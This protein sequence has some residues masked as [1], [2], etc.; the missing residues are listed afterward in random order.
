MVF[1]VVA[2]LFPPHFVSEEV[3]SQ[4]CEYDEPVAGPRGQER[5]RQ[6]GFRGQRFGEQ[7]LN[8]LFIT[9]SR[10]FFSM[11]SRFYRLLQEPKKGSQG[12]QKNSSGL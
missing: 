12:V 9:F 1:L 3:F 6:A 11:D 2:R 8:L 4:L 10:Q 5:R 7:N